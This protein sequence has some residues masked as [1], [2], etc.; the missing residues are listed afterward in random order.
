MR[1]NARAARSLLTQRLRPCSLRGLRPPPL[2]SPIRAACDVPRGVLRRPGVGAF[3]PLRGFSLRCSSPPLRGL[4]P[5]P[6]AVGPSPNPGCFCAPGGRSFVPRFSRPPF[7]PL[8]V[9]PRPLRCRLRA[10][11]GPGRGARRCSLSLAGPLRQPPAPKLAPVCGLSPSVVAS[12]PVGSSSPLRFAA[13]SLRGRSPLLLSVARF[14]PLVG[15]RFPLARPLRGFG[16]GAAPRTGGIRRLAA[17]FFS[18]APPVLSARVLAPACW[19]PRPGAVL[20]GGVLPCALPSRRPRWGL[21]EAR[22]CSSR[23]CAPRFAGP[24]GC[25]RCL[26]PRLLILAP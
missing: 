3:L 23:A 7:C 6:A 18:A 24:P 2:R 4:A 20:W 17:A 1:Q 21:R 12:A 5:L 8:P 22:G 13:G 15:R 10:G 26:R 9:P 11:S 14:S 25:V 16:T 19:R